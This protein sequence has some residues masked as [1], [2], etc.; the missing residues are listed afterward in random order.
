MTFTEE[1]RRVADFLEQLSK[2]YGY[3][4]QRG[5]WSASSLRYEADHLDKPIIGEVGA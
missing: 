2:L 5:T 4:P 1:M 3:D